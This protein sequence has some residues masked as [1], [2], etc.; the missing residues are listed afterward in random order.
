MNEVFIEVKGMWNFELTALGKVA[1]VLLINMEKL[2]TYFLC[3]CV[4]K[5][6]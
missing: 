3:M 5:E 6:Q 1:D 2:A 4:W